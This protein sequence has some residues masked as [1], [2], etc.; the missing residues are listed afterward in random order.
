MPRIQLRD[1]CGTRSGDKGDIVNIALFAYDAAAYEAIRREVT[2]ARVASHFGGLIN[3]QVSRYEAPNV[4]AL[5]FV[6]QVPSAAADPARCAATTSARR[7]AAGCCAWR[8]RF[9]VRSPR[10]LRGGVRTCRATRAS[11][12]VRRAARTPHRGLAAGRG[13]PVDAALTCAHCPR[14]P[15]T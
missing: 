10:R 5:N 1:L 15:A 11:D 14:A 2:A 7:W 13:G 8:S 12:L 4:L 3:G 9:R 6:A